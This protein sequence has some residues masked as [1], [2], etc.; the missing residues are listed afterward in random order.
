MELSLYFQF[1]FND[2]HTQMVVHWAGKNSKVIIAHTKG[3]AIGNYSAHS[4]HVYVS[5]TYGENFTVIDDKL[6]LYNGSQA[7]ISQYFTSPV[8]NTHVS[9][10]LEF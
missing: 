2:S 3:R 10:I 8:E 5:H 1:A 7:L 6:K 9:I 4:S